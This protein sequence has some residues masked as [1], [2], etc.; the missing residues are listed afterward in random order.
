MA[1]QKPLAANLQPA[2]FRGVPFQV[3]AN[4]LGAG[5]RNQ[6]HEYPQRDKPY[7]E[8]LGRAARE[9]SF[10][11]FVVGADYVDQVKKLLAAFETAGPGT[12][13]HPW[14]GSM[15][16]SLKDRGR[17][18][19][20]AALGYASV[21]LEFIEAGELEFP[22]VSTSTPA[23]SRLA[24]SKIETSAV[25]SFTKE[26]SVRGVQDF[27]S[28][29]ALSTAGGIVSA[30]ADSD[31][32]SFDGLGF[33]EDADGLL[34]DLGDLIDYPLELASSLADF[35]SL[36]DVVALA[37]WAMDW[38]SVIDGLLRMWGSPPLAAPVRP[39]I[40]TPSR[41]QAYA[42]TRASKALA[43][44]MLL[45]QAVGLSSLGEAKVFDE[46]VGVRDRLCSALDEECMTAP[47]E[48]YTALQDARGAVWK[49][50]TVRS[51]DSA[52]LATLQPPATAP[53]LVLAYDYYEDATRE[54]DIV[55]RNRVR[56]PGFVP[57]DPLRVL[58]R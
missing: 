40:Y 48:V 58:T 36:S 5:R 41:Q 9:L 54:A 11:A 1:D 27:V 53:A 22:S 24:A 57:P 47:D 8:D 18:R 34:G 52:R 25:N 55:A 17:V 23:Q 45:A 31:F 29:A 37:G 20:S 26:F 21:A 12:L 7:V 32:L 4:E 51:R 49:D 14:F 56:H 46:S 28:A 33:A 15:Q 50:L 13:V 16:V 6:L 30:I 10:E 19:F 39:S 38:S 44:Q 42:N 3:E 35:I 2:S 43:R